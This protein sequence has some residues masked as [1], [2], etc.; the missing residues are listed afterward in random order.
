MRIDRRARPV[1][2]ILVVATLLSAACSSQPGRVGEPVVVAG[3]DSL[4][5]AQFLIASSQNSWQADDLNYR[6]QSFPSGRE[7]LNAVL[8]G[9]AT[10]GTVGDLPTVTAILAGENVRILG[11]LTEGIDW[12]VLTTTNTGVRGPSDLAGRKIGVTQGTNTQ[13]LLDVVLGSAGLTTGDVELVNLSPNQI[14]GALAKGD[15]DVGIT[16][17]TFYSAARTA[18]GDSYADFVFDGYRSPTLLL[19]SA[20]A[21]AGLVDKLVS[22]LVRAQTSVDRGDDTIAAIAA[23]SNGALTEEQVRDLY[24]NYRIG[25]GIDDDLVDRLT[26]EAQWASTTLGVTGD[27]SR[28]HIASY[29]HSEP[30]HSADPSAVDLSE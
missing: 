12:R 6:S 28:E 19:A 20:D 1:I 8:G 25:L 14:P 30:L 9:N 26:A 13:Y 23:G 2:A 10:F 18:L 4:G 17:P 21:P 7:A 5:S 15:I 11:A 24:P 3:G 29:F 22:V 16:F 27:S